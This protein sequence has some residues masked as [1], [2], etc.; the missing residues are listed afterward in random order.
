VQYRHTRHTINPNTTTPT[1]AIPMYRPTFEVDSP[2]APLVDPSGVVEDCGGGGLLSVPFEAGA[3][4]ASGVA[5]GVVAVAVN[6]ALLI[7]K[8]FSEF[9]LLESTEATTEETSIV[10]ST[11]ISNIDLRDRQP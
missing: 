6:R 7:L 10:Q 4:A 1:N 5:A 2:L 3:A 8:V 11:T 9:K